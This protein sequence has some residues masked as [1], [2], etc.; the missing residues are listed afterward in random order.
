ML[1]PN[2]KSSF[3][4]VFASTCKSQHFLLVILRQFSKVL[5]YYSF[6]AEHKK[7]QKTCPLCWYKFAKI[8]LIW[9]CSPCWVKLKEF[10][11]VIMMHPFTDLFL[12]ICII[13]NIYFLA[14]ECYPMSAATSNVLNIGNLVRLLFYVTFICNFNLF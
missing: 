12:T 5:L 1:I 11:H 2:Q 9:N 7:S 4:P 6:I 13:L 10:V 3:K 14:M 8:F